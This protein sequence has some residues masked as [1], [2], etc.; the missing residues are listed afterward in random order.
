MPQSRSVRESVIASVTFCLPYHSRLFVFTASYA[1]S[2]YDL[3]GPQ[4][5]DCFSMNSMDSPRF[6]PL[7]LIF[8]AF[9]LS[10]PISAPD[11]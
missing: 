9:S 6:W 2:V 7:A 10:P 3:D 4:Q 8:I 1:H 5:L 11:Y